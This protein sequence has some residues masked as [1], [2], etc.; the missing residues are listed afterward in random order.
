MMSISVSKTE[1]DNCNKLTDAGASDEEFR[2]RD[3]D[4]MFLKAHQD[5]LKKI[6]ISSSWP[7]A[8]YQQGYSRSE[9][10]EVSEDC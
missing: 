3:S 10:N 1:N 2:R 6:M 4:A 8:E 7:E 5:N 9:I